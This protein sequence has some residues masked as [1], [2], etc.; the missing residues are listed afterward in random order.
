M[1]FLYPATLGLNA[2]LSVGLALALGATGAHAQSVITRQVDTEPVETTV[3]QTPGGTVI[4]RRPLA[5]AVGAVTVAPSAAPPYGVGAMRLQPYTP[6]PPPASAVTSATADETVG[7]EP[8]RRTAAPPRTTTRVVH[9]ERNAARS[10]PRSIVRK[11]AN[12]STSAR[13]ATSTVR[14]TTQRVAVA[15]PLVLDPAQRHVVYRTIVQQQIVPPPGYPPFPA[16]AY[17]AYP[18]RTVVV[19]PAATTGYAVTTP[20]DEIYESDVDADEL[21]PEPLPVRYAVGVQLPARIVPRPLPATA[22]VEVP[23]V[24]PYS[25]VTVDNRVLLVDPATNTVVADITP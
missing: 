22:A 8:A 4:T 12:T 11:T 20:A 14:R 2:G 5:P 16:P 3:T 17:R 18:A 9:H 7:V 21:P 24:R 23:S 19:P 15:P 6:A 25:Y 13:I 10:E 1:R